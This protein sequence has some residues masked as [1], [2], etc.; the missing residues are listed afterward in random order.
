MLIPY[1]QDRKQENYLLAKIA[2]NISASL[3]FGRE[4]KCFIQRSNKK[5]K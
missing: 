2:N 5:D 4:G 1:L 3:H